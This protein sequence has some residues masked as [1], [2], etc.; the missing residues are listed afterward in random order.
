ML[1]HHLK[2]VTAVGYHKLVFIRKTFHTV[3]V[4][5]VYLQGVHVLYK[6]YMWQSRV[7]IEHY[8]IAYFDHVTTSWRSSVELSSRAWLIRTV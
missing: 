6:M 8:S 1:Y 3:L 4:H 5:K 7:E 2:L